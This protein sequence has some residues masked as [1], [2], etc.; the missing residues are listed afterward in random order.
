MKNNNLVPG[1]CIFV[2]GT[3]YKLIFIGNNLPN[4]KQDWWVEPL[5]VDNNEVTVVTLDP[6]IRYKRLHYDLRTARGYIEY[7]KASA[8]Y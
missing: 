4:G 3:P 2:N 1:R 8:I 7:R 5:F 6:S